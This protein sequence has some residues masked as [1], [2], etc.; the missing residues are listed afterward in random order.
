M[1][2]A[3]YKDNIKK[4]GSPDM[5]KRN[6]LIFKLRRE[7]NT[8]KKVSAIVNISVA[9]VRQLE[10]SCCKSLLKNI[11]KLKQRSQKHGRI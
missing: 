6:W 11:K 5:S 10:I 8:L 3:D 2:V 4:N 9:R 7:G 1:S